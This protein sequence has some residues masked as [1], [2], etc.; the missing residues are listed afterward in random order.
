MFYLTTHST[1]F[2]YSYMPSDIIMIKGHSESERITRCPHY[3]GYSF[4]V[5]ARRF[6]MHH[7]TNRIAHTMVFI[8][9]VVEHWLVKNHCPSVF[10]CSVFS[11]SFFLSFFN[12]FSICWCAFRIVCTLFLCE[13]SSILFV[14][15][16][17]I[18]IINSFKNHVIVNFYFILFTSIH[19]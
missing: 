2:I 9:L 14:Y 17:F 1:Y 6:Y 10:I 13:S 19:S 7:L 11:I 3:T 5:V 18:I 8:T 12:F 4:R 16:I 15:L